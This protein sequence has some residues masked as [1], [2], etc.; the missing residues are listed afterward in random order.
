MI[1]HLQR[2]KQAENLACSY[3]QQHGLQLI[4][5]NF[6]CRFGEIDLVMQDKTSLVFVEVR[7][8][9]DYGF[10][11]SAESIT[12]HK[13]RKLRNTAQIYLQNNPLFGKK[14]CRFD[15]VAIDIVKHQSKVEWI[16]NAF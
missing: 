14:A 16:K 5:R 3:L 13:Q 11:S 1:N 15:V 8:R 2:G 9:I 12:S 4:E 6:R 10:G 7:Y